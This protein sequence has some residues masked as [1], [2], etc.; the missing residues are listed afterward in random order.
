MG[1]VHAQL[2]RLPRRDI[3]VLSRAEIRLLEDV[4]SSE[5]DKLIVRVSPTPASGWRS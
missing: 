5:R 2:P 3:E 1:D 4:A